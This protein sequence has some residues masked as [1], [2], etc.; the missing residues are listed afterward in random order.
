[1]CYKPDPQGKCEGGPDCL[2]ANNKTYSHL[3]HQDMRVSHDAVG[4]GVGKDWGCF[5]CKLFQHEF[6]WRVSGS[7]PHKPKQ[8]C[9]WPSQEEA[10][11]VG[12]VLINPYLA[13]C[14]PVL[15]S[16]AGLLLNPPIILLFK[17]ALNAQRSQPVGSA[18][19]LTAR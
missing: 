6:D 14:P 8:S 11:V 2:T 7:I 4:T 16:L 10:L 13:S 12:G 5:K 15:P 19:R 3:G 18:Y 9:R 17:Y 1:M